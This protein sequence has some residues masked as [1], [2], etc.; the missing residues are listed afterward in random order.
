MLTFI[1]QN[2]LLTG[3]VSA[4]TVALLY[5]FFFMSGTPAP[6]LSN[7]GGGES[8]ITQSLLVTLSS[9]H[10]LKLDGSLFTDPAFVSLTDFGVVIPPESVGRHNPFAPIVTPSGTAAQ[11][12]STLKLPTS[13]K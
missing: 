6:I 9:L 12:V 8:P 7:T 2:K 3:A 1:T 4:A 11:T 5:Y 13:A 10:T